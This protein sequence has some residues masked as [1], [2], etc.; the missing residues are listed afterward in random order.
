M[1]PKSDRAKPSAGGSFL[2]FETLLL[3]EYLMS[4]YTCN[5]HSG[6]SIQFC[7]KGSQITW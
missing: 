5:A 2:K 6:K 1:R 4:S 3:P 7:Y